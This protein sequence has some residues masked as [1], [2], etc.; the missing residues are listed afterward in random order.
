MGWGAYARDK[1]T[2]TRLCA[3]MQGGAYLQ[4][5]TVDA[6]PFISSD[7][8]PNVACKLCC[9]K[10]FNSL[11]IQRKTQL[12]L[13][14]NQFYHAATPYPPTSYSSSFTC[15]TCCVISDY[16][17]TLYNFLWSIFTIASV[18]HIIQGSIFLK[19]FTFLNLSLL[20]EHLF[21]CISDNFYHNHAT[22]AILQ[23]H[24]HRIPN[25]CQK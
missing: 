7:V 1:N 10:T 14:N 5:T 15:S 16:F 12:L 13:P 19:V 4:D 8:Y 18:W 20:A 2:S 9:F 6:K 3:K 23:G 22:K 17:E 11:K 24:M 25:L 21:G